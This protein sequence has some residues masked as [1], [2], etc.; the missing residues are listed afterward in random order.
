MSRCSWYTSK[1]YL[2]VSLLVVLASHSCGVL[3]C[4]RLKRSFI[5]IYHMDTSD[6]ELSIGLGLG[7]GP[8]SSP[9]ELNSRPS[10]ITQEK[11][12][13][14]CYKPKVQWNENMKIT[15]AII[16]SQ[17]KRNGKG[18]MSRVEARWRNYFHM[19]DML[20]MKNLRDRHAKL[21]NDT[22]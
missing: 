14:C 13:R 9:A 18:W 6:Q 17:E 2:L 21:S 15:L 19:Y 7:Q 16:V 11:S 12:K 1:Y 8:S 4:S 10:R 3:N 5:A 20:N 22:I